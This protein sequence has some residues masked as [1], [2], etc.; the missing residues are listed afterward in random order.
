MKVDSQQPA[1]LQS[2]IYEPEGIRVLTTTRRG[3]GIQ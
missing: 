1:D 2:N 3:Y